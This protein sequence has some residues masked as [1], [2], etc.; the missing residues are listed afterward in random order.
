MSKPSSC[1]RPSPL[2]FC[3]LHG[4]IRLGKHVNRGANCCKSLFIPFRSWHGV[5]SGTARRLLS[6]SQKQYRVLGDIITPL[7]YTATVTTTTVTTTT[8]TTYLSYSSSTSRSLSRRVTL[9][10][11]FSR[12]CRRALSSLEFSLPGERRGAWERGEVGS[13][14]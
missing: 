1:S 10:A 14:C 3:L 7:S 11:K 13:E 2:E 8:T 6:F 4:R 5:S 12:P 9:G